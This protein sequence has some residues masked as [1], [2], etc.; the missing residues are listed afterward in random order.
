[1]SLGEDRD[2]H[3]C[4]S[5][6]DWQVHVYGE[7]APGLEA[8]CRQRSLP[9]HRF[10][11]EPGMRRTGIIRDAM[12]LIRPDGYIALAGSPGSGGALAAYLD[13]R[14]LSG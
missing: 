13:A 4:L 7:A 5:S 1:V 11:W 2:N 3:S 14:Q 6:L 8:I 12:Y 10:A 9:L